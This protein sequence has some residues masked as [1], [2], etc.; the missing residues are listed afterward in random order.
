MLDEMIGRLDGVTPYA[1]P[2]DRTHTY[3]MYGFSIDPGCFTCTADEFAR[4]LAEAGIPGSGIGRYYLMPAAMP[5]LTE[6]VE[7]GMYPFS[8]PPASHVYHYSADSCPNAKRFLD[9][10]IR[11]AWTEKYTPAHLE[12]IAG[13]IEQTVKKNL[14]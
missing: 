10:W 6:N 8:M 7:N 2:D 1:I 4:Q 5:F 9:T 13:L 11:W 14:K 12:F 3:W